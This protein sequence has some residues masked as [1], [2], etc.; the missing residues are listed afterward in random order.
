MLRTQYTGSCDSLVSGKNGWTG[1]YG[2]TL[3]L[4][5]SQDIS[6]Y[7]VVLETSQPLSSFT[8]WSS[9]SVGPTSGSK[10]TVT[11]K[12]WFGGLKAGDTLSLAFQVAYTGSSEPTF[13]SIFLNGVKVC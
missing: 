1:A 7:T 12:S 11:N 13:T 6:S 8:T 2:G 9:D 5:V 10:I 4:P 3:S